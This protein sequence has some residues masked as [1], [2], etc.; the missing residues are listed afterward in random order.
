MKKSYILNIILN[1]IAVWI[2]ATLPILYSDKVI[3]FDTLLVLSLILAIFMGVLPWLASINYPVSLT[4]KKFDDTLDIINKPKYIDQNF[5]KLEEL[6][7]KENKIRNRYN[8]SSFFKRPIV[9]YQQRFKPYIN[10]VDMLYLHTLSQLSEIGYEIVLLIYDFPYEADDKE[11]AVS[12]HKIPL[13]Y[14]HDLNILQQ[15]IR[16]IIGHRCKVLNASEFQASHHEAKKFVEVIHQRFIPFF[17]NNISMFLTDSNGKQRTKYEISMWVRNFFGFTTLY[18]LP[19]RHLIFYLTCDNRKD[20]WQQKKEILGDKADEVFIISG[21]TITDK[22]GNRINMNDEKGTINFTDTDE[23][24]ERKVK[25]ENEEV[26]RAIC[27][28]ILFSKEDAELWT[29]TMLENRANQGI[30]QYK[31]SK[32]IIE[33]Y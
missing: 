20:V 29:K 6:Q 22:N 2:V 14:Q 27:Q 5:L 8:K 31:K 1:A 23:N 21:R 28:S 10:Y 4:H 17:A 19:R 16:N 9:F 33:H 24:I 11:G 13:E 30:K 32:S 3:T 12:A 25:N 26:L 7:E 18:L 15:N